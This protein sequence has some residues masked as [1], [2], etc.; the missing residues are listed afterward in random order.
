MNNNQSSKNS[1]RNFLGTLATGAAAIG[2]S[3]VS[4]LTAGAKKITEDF[5]TPGD[6]PEAWLK[7]ITGKHR[8][9]Y[10]APEPN[11]IMPFAWS[12]VFLITN[13]MTGTK[14]GNNTVVVVLRHESIPFA[15]EDKLWV[16]YKFGEMFKINDPATGKP[17]VRNAFWKPQVGD[18]KVPGL[19]NVAIGINEL[20]DSGVIFCVCNMAL[21]VYSAVA[22]DQMKLTAADVHKEWRSGV[23]PGIEIVPSGVWALGRAQEK[24]C[25]YIFAG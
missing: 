15:M 17:A 1:R 23:L 4:P 8:V 13:E 5:Q 7:R 25:G 22:A 18:F 11:G 6:D 16:K 20:Q 2:L 14:T 19:G 21:T 3:T 12:R 9:V 24:G 10:D